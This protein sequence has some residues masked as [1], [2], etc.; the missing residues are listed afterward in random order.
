MPGTLYIVAA[1]SGAGKTSLTKA[2]LEQEPGIALS[3][4]YTSRLPRPNE[5]DGVHYHFMTR[6]AFLKLHAARGFLEAN[7]VHLQH[8][9]NLATLERVTAGGF[10][11]G[12]VPAPTTHP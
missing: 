4:S 1:P 2:L 7:E 10:N 11:A 9:L 3:V 8:L 12:F 6:E 5:V